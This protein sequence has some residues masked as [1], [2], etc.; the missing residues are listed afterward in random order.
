MSGIIVFILR[1]LLVA[2]LYSFLIWAI[3]TLW[4]QL[5]LKSS[6]IVDI[7]APE[8]TL[9][10]DGPEEIRQSFTNVEITLGREPTCD[11]TIANDIVSSYHARLRYSQKQWWIEDLQSTN[12]TFLDNER[13]YTPTVIVSGEELKLGKIKI[14]ISIQK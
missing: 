6:E 10:M 4:R 9:S 11:F 8:I 5:Q 3:Y 7:P 13:I 14:Q 1:L 2:S 12:G